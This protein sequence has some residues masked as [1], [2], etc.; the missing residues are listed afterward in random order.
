MRACNIR[1]CAAI[2]KY[3][4]YLEKALK[5]ENHKIT[6]FTGA[7]Y[8]DNL[9]TRGDLHQGPSFETISSIGPNG[10]IIHYSPEED[11][12]VT[13]NRDEIYLLDSGGQYLDG[14]TDITRT[15]HFGGKAP[16]AFQ[17]EAYTRV[18]RGCL[19]LERVVWPA[20]ARIAGG[21]MDTLARKALWEVGLDYKH[22]TGHGVGSYLNV[23]EGPVGVSRGYKVEWVPG[24]CVSDEPG[25]YQ[26]GE[27]GI[28]I[29]NVIMCQ[30]HPQHDN[31]LCWENLTTAP[32]SR[33]LI[34]KN[35]L[36]PDTV[37]YI[38]N[39]HQKCLTALTPLLQDDA[40]A[41]D[42]V[43]RQCAPL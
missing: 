5:E 39:F 13:L 8:L 31:Y 41:L 20:K 36:S 14:T 11:T 24:H 23:H 9:R 19:D 17:K 6:E 3:F 21:D 4:A 40:D 33:D 12:A 28:R 22:G 35:F 29:E 18:L 42:Y 2:M 10:A 26:D 15:T 38:D 25:Y 43:K 32:Y 1:D 30:V 16:T 37:A 34:D 7:K 27:F